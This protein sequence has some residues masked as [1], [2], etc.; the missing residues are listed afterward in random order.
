MKVENI[1]TII[2]ILI[3][4]TLLF[5][6]IIIAQRLFK[7]TT[8]AKYDA[9]RPKMAPI[10]SSIETFLQNTGQ[11]PTTL[12]DLIENPGL[13]GWTG[14]YLKESQL[15]DPWDR[16]YIYIPNGTNNSNNFDIISYGADGVPGGE[17]I[18]AD[19]YND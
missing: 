14:P 9:A 10:E 15:Y 17:G 5:F 6:S 19:I 2:F 13:P 1:L 11:Y 3:I 12:N 8:S 18:N 16:M 7:Q 4:L